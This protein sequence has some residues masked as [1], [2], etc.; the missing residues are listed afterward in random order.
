MKSIFT[1]YSIYTAIMENMKRLIV[2][3]GTPVIN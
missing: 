3:T 1:V 2:K